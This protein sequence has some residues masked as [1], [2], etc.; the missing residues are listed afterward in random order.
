MAFI[1]RYHIKS[2]IIRNEVD[3]TNYE[4]DITDGIKE[5]FLAN[6]KD[7]RVECNYFEFKLHFSVDNSI[8]RLF[9]RTLI[10]RS[11]KLRTV[12]TKYNINN[13]QGTLYENPWKS[14]AVF[15][16]IRAIKYM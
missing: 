15:Y 12:K 3:L 9:G 2:P 4:K 1:Y 10:N 14:M 7:C 8:L 13:I 11:P 5:Y 16:Q 6:L